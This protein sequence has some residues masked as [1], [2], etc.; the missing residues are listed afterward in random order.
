MAKNS[1][2]YTCK[3]HKSHKQQFKYRQ[4][5]LS[6]LKKGPNLAKIVSETVIIINDNNRIATFL[7]IIIQKDV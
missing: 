4:K 7:L 6:A 5:K 2:T 3:T 1:N